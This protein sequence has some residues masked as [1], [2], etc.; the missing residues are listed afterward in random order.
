MTVR[1]YA[2]ASCD[3]N[4]EDWRSRTDKSLKLKEAWLDIEVAYNALLIKSTLIIWLRRFD[5]Q[6]SVFPSTRDHVKVQLI[7]HC[8]IVNKKESLTLLPNV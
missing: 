1:C 7:E 3:T 5:F 2:R 8:V 4:L 6:L